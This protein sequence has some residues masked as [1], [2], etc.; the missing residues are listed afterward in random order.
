MSKVLIYTENYLPGGGNRYLI[1]LV[2]GIGTNFEIIICSNRNGLFDHDFNRIR[3]DYVYYDLNVLSIPRIY[4]F[5]GRQKK[6]IQLS[7]IILLKIS[8][9]LF[10]GVFKRR[11][12]KFFAN[13]IQEFKPELIIS[14][15]GGFPGG[16]SC[17]DMVY[18]AKKSDIP[19]ILT[20]VS[21]PKKPNMYIKLFYPNVKYYC[22]QIVV[23]TDVIK[24]SFINNYHFLEQKIV[25]IHNC[26]DSNDL[27]NVSG[28]FQQELESKYDLKGY[29]VLGFVG[30]IEKLKG[31]YILLEA[32]KEVL[33]V[34]KNIKLILVGSGEIEKAK[35]FATRLNIH[36]DVIFTGFC[37]DNIFD[38]IDAF[39]IFVF[40]S[41][42]EG[43]PY[44]ILEAMVMQKMII[45]SDVGGI[46]E[47]IV[48]GKTGF[49]VK[50]NDPDLLAAK[51]KITLTERERYKTFGLNAKTYVDENF[52]SI[53]FAKE[54]NQIISE[55]L[56]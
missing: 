28:S 21:V 14:C 30:R 8:A 9:I 56:V 39:D 46:P 10:T 22:N 7:I 38:V 33:E 2:N 49:L 53:R 15:N 37:N 18:A 55:V 24:H 26:I 54:I 29:Q 4:R 16:F 42:W 48:D 32:F 35:I 40:P 20:V 31:V 17:L 27:R 41:L 25:T 45:A 44:S 47:L 50:P 13:T 23:N 3:R 5:A 6:Y 34:H 36:D 19:V 52:S 43:L 11:N 1:D 51:L 12:I